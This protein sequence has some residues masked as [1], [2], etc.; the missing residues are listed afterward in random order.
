MLLDWNLKRRTF[1]ISIWIP[2]I[3]S[4]FIWNTT[5]NVSIERFPS[6]VCFSQQ[7]KVD[8][9]EDIII[10]HFPDRTVQLLHSKS[11]SVLQGTCNQCGNENRVQKYSTRS[12]G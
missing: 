8:L 7:A 6:H 12:R 10:V 4:P 3:L 11:F 9:Q 5:T 1:R 2:P